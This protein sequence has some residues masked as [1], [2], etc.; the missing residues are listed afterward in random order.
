MPAQW[1]TNGPYTGPIISSVYGLAV[2]GTNLFAGGEDG[3]FLSTDNGASWAATNV[4]LTNTR[5]HVLFASGANL[6]A[7]T[8]GGGAFLSTN[9]GASWSATGLT[10]IHVSTFVHSGNDLFAG[11][12]PGGVFL[13]TNNGESWT[14]TNAGLTNNLIFDLAVSGAYLFAGTHGS[15]VFRSTDNGASWTD[16]GL[17]NLYAIDLAVSGTNLFAGTIGDGVFRST[18]N[19][20]SWTLTNLGH[21]RIAT[22]AV[23]DTNLF[24]GTYGSGVFLTTDNGTSWTH[25]GLEGSVVALAVSGPYL[26]AAN[27]NGV[28][29]RPLSDLLTSAESATSIPSRCLL[30]Q[31][32]PNPFNPTTVVSCQLPVAS[33]VRLVVYDLLGREVAV[34]MDETKEAGRYEVKFDGSRLASGAYICRMQATDPALRSGQ[35]FVQTR[36]LFLLK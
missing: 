34:L 32:Y 28:W 33:K 25:A 16:A 24:A 14:S 5:V 31:N 30:E 7:G 36:K 23:S 20:A 4:G 35:A 21:S 11:T 12:Y 8:I 29:R 19:G 6:F 9:D 15:G 27:M 3:V 18:N 10:Q 13:S 1:V 26:F 2:S 22:L 17:Q